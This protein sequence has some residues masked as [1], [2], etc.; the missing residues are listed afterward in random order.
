MKKPRIS[1]ND[2]N[3][4]LND[5]WAWKEEVNDPNLTILDII[6]EYI[7]K[8]NL[9][10]DTVG[11]LLAQNKNFVKILENDLIKS[12]IFKSEKEI[13]TFNEWE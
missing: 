11:E 1:G 9:C 12:R 10:P 13:T 5:I 8:N 7:E 2:S 6:S 4:I 3:R